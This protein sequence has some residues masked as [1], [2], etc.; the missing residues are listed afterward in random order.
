MSNLHKHLMQHSA[1]YKNWHKNQP[2]SSA[3]HWTLFILVS[4][5]LTYTALNSID[6][7]Y[8]QQVASVAAYDN[9]PKASEPI[10]GS[11]I[12]TFTDDVSDIPGLAKQLAAQSG[13]VAKFTY[14]AALKGMALSN[15]PDAAVDGL[16]HNP[17]VKMVEQDSTMSATA[18]QDFP[19]TWGLDFIDQHS[20]TLNGVYSYSNNGA[21]V[22]AYVF[23]T[24]ILASHVEFGGRVMPGYTA[25]NDG[26]GTDDCG[27][28]GT[29]VA[30]V[31]GG[32]TVGVA[33]GVAIYPVRIADCNGLAQWSSV[34]AGMDWVMK[35]PHH[36]A[37]AN[38]SYSGVKSSTIDSAIQ[39]FIKSGVTVVVS[40]GN[41]AMDACTRSPADVPEAI[42]AGAMASFG[43]M[44]GFSNYGPCVDL[45]APGQ[46]LLGARNINNTSYGPWSGTSFS[47]P[48]TA[49][50]AA[51]YLSANP[52]ATPAQVSQALVSAATPGIITGIPSGPN[53]AL[54]S[55]FAT[56]LTVPQSLPTPSIVS[57]KASCDS[58][59]LPQVN[60]YYNPI[61]EESGPMGVTIY[62]NGAIVENW[63]GSQFDMTSSLPYE[64]DGS[65]FSNLPSNTSVSYQ[66]VLRFTGYPNSALSAP[67]TLTTPNCSGGTP[68]PPPPTGD[69]VSPSVPQNLSAT[70]QD[71]THVALSWSASTDNVGVTGYKLYRNGSLL[72]SVTS[73][74]YT[75]SSVVAGTSYSYAVSAYDAAGNASAQSTSASVTTP[76]VVSPPP[77]TTFNIGDTVFT[78]SKVNV[79][80]T[81]TTKGKP[82]GTQKAG[83]NG[84]ITNRPQTGAGYTW[85]YVDFASGTDGWVTQ[86]YL[87]K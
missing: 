31:L 65:I 84:V 7:N 46:N 19:P 44:S 74:S 82:L 22:S 73:T 49:G 5:S 21:G 14:T 80:S 75:D 30:S 50:V 76:S 10:P 64:I 48:Y 81:P 41:D 20:S 32:T 53:L 34:I 85:W 37:V 61:F 4:L 25:I 33:K 36:P 13:G 15:V 42:T 11:Y 78:T 16:K 3:V 9:Q 72:S 39:N 77:P 51:L 47:S 63:S 43:A 87:S 71:Q 68:P 28:H 70:A 40:A 24:G 45:F 58:S 55:P 57:T 18:Q 69:T 26:R 54:Y 8:K 35:N 86:D 59:G 29:G 60:L 79:R 6:L 66:I 2:F 12:I 62:R 38:L 67:V 52:T 83:A 23:D 56:N 27:I 17:R 1:L